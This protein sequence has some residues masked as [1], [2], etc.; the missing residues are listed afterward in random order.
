MWNFDPGGMEPSSNDLPLMSNIKDIRVRHYLMELKVDLTQRIFSGSVTLFLEKPSKAELARCRKADSVSGEG[1]PLTNEN[2]SSTRREGQPMCTTSSVCNLEEI[3]QNKSCP[4]AARKPTQTGTDSCDTENQECFQV[5]ILTPETCSHNSSMEGVLISEDC[6]EKVKETDH[7]HNKSHQL[8]EC[9]NHSQGQDYS[10]STPL[11]EMKRLASLPEEFVLILDSCEIDV[12]SVT[13]VIVDQSKLKPEKF[14]SNNCT[15]FKT[16]APDHETCGGD[17]DG[18]IDQNIQTTTNSIYNRQRG[19]TCISGAGETAKSSTVGHSLCNIFCYESCDFTSRREQFLASRLMTKRDISFEV[20]PWC[21][22]IW[23]SGVRDVNDFPAVINIQYNTRPCGKSLTW[24]HDQDGNPCVF[25]QGAWINNRSL[26]PCQEPPGA[27]ATWQAIIQA[28]E[29]LTV[30]MSGDEVGRVIVHRDGLVSTIHFTDMLQPSSIVAIA[31]GQWKCHDIPVS[32]SFPECDD[33]EKKQSPFNLPQI[34]NRP[35]DVVCRHEEWPCRIQRTDQPILPSRIIAPPSLFQSAVSEFAD[36]LPRCLEAV[37][38]LLGAHPFSRLDLLVLPRCFASLGLASPSLIFLSQ[39]LLAGDG[40]FQP[41]LAHEISHSW[42]GIL[43]GALDWTEEWLSEGFATFME[44]PVHALAKNWTRKEYQ[45]H[46]DLR[47]LIRYRSLKA[48]LEN[49]EAELQIMRPMASETPPTSSQEGSEV[50]YVKNGLNP[51]K[52]FLQVHYLKGYFLLCHLAKHL[53]F[54]KMLSFICLYV[55]RY[56]GQL[57]LSRDIFQLLFETYPELTCHGITMENIYSDWLDKPGMP[58][59]LTAE[60]FSESNALIAQVKQE[61]DKW[62]AFNK[63]H[64]KSKSRKKKKR[65][66]MQSGEVPSSNLTADQL[67]LLLEYLLDVVAMAPRTLAELKGAYHLTRQNAEVRHRWCE[68]V[69][70]HK[71]KESYNDVSIFLWEDQAMGVYL[72]GELMASEDS[73]QQDLARQCFQA[74]A[75]EMDRG[76][77][78]TVHEMLYGEPATRDDDSKRGLIES[79]LRHE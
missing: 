71:H 48:E 51:D 45:D 40:S 3:R 50:N 52:W 20:Q 69:V 70:K 12:H 37:F 25:T 73:Q 44:D 75:M 10:N 54:D 46:S 38:N 42:F 24:A 63:S 32:M 27:M 56:H 55:H 14:S 34:R 23:K 33:E 4:A 58:T 72:Y 61:F 57:V 16:T 26:F 28:P 66:L 39:S 31:I 11:K 59:S 49:T 67:I 13:E 7:H 29:E 65:K 30:L 62:V 41:R 74:V 60:M 47:A 78:R 2:D 22:R 8:A 76:C 1:V 6:P 68:L 36:Y 35:Q 43:I 64:M 5:G 19:E 53:S 77:Y 21:V 17:E 15:P 9:D 79:I 18:E